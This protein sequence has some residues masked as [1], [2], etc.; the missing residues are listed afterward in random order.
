ML[1]SMVS[2]DGSFTLS[3]QENGSTSVSWIGNAQLGTYL[4]QLVGGLLEGLV[5]E[6]LKRFIE[7]MEA[8]LIR[9]G[10]LCYSR[11]S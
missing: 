3:R 2:V 5:Q 9:E 1:K 4:M 6:N 7:A 8:E 10:G 11:F